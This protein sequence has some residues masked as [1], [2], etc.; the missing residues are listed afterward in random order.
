[1]SSVSTSRGRAGAIV[2][3]RPPA[4]GQYGD[5]VGVSPAI[6]GIIGNPDIG[7]IR[8]AIASPAGGTAAC[9]LS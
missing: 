6:P 3:A 7:G 1:M 9:A 5:T 4:L 2:P 8:H